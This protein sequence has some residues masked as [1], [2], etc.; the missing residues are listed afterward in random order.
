MRVAWV[1]KLKPGEEAAYKKKHDEIWPELAA[2]IKQRG[3]RNYS[4]Y[5]HGLTLFAYQEVDE[6][7]TKQRE[8]D[9]ITLRWQ[10]WMAPHMETHQDFRPVVEA[11]EEVFHID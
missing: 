6:P 7:V 2:L 3:V 11:V 8:R 5:R 9:A 10:E 1:M 4:I